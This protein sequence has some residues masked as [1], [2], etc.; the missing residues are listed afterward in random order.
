MKSIGTK[1][2]RKV[3]RLAALNGVYL[4]LCLA[5]LVPVLYALTLSF[6]G[7]GA[8]LSSRFSFLTAQPNIEN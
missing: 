8:A 2:V 6:S 4:L 7:S 3:L 1:R 5:A